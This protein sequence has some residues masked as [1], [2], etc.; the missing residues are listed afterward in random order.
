MRFDQFNAINHRLQQLARL[1]V[2]APDPLGQAGGV[3]TVQQVLD[4]HLDFL[5]YE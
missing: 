5:S 3:F 2:T 1:H 4:V